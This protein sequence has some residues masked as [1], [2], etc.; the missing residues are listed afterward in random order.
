MT[1]GIPLLSTHDEM[2]EALRVL[3]AIGILPVIDRELHETR[4]SDIER[5]N[6][7][8]CEA[9]EPD[10]FRP[11]NAGSP[12]TLEALRAGK[13]ERI[14]IVVS[15]VCWLD[16]GPSIDPLR[17]QTFLTLYR[18]TPVPT[19]RDASGSLWSRAVPD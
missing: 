5:L 11:L 2:P 16:I 19:L 14:R 17:L 1:N 7:E 6:V 9:T 4:P 15:S 18:C 13:P 12:L 10:L 8:V 3:D